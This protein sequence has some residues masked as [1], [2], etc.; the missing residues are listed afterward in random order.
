MPHVSEINAYLQDRLCYYIA[1]L[2]PTDTSMF[3]LWAQLGSALRPPSPSPVP[4]HFSSAKTVD[5]EVLECT[6]GPRSI[7]CPACIQ[8]IVMVS[9]KSHLF[10]ENSPCL[11]PV[12]RNFKRWVCGLHRSLLR[13]WW[14]R[15]HLFLFY[16]MAARPNSVANTLPGIWCSIV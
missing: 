5:L 3:L 15:C 13:Y 14:Y 12:G 8:N 2:Y 7:R 10:S 1:R 4:H 11:H 16:T 6:L 9:I